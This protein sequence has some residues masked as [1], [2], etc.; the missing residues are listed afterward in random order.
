[1]FNCNPDS[2]EEDSDHTHSPWQ[3]AG[4]PC[5]SCD[6]NQTLYVWP[7]LGVQKEFRKI[8]QPP[9]WDAWSKTP[10]RTPNQALKG[11]WPRLQP[12]VTL[13]RG[14]PWLFQPHLAF[15]DVHYGCSGDESW[16]PNLPHSI[17]MSRLGK[18][19]SV[20]KSF[21]HSSEHVITVFP[22]A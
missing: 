6:A 21:P 15:S 13:E 18:H 7:P 17:Q 3:G 10:A 9:Q 16:P 8:S 2:R 11:P 19:T 4:G 5:C 22:V 1:M 14:T 12:P 20:S